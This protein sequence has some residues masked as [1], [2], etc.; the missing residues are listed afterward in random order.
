MVVEVKVEDDWLIV[1]VQVET[2]VAFK[3]IC[4]REAEE[5]KSSDRSSEHT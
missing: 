4:S 1:P 5:V 3:V 2:H